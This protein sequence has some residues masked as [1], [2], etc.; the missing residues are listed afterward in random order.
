MSLILSL[1]VPSRIPSLVDFF[2]V[3]LRTSQSVRIS[4]RLDVVQPAAGSGSGTR[5]AG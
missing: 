3:R 2:G 4:Q 1:G 5:R